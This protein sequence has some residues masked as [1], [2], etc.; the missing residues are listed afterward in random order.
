M[1]SNH[2]TM[3]RFDKLL[4]AWRRSQAQATAYWLSHA[5]C[6]APHQRFLVEQLRAV[7]NAWYA[8]MKDE[9]AAQ[10]RELPLL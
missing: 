9:L 7:A 2:S 3:T 6:R 10:R 8:L 4:L 1:R 5:G